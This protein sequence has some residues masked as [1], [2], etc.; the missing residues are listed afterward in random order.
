M[1]PSATFT[2][3]PLGPSHDRA[4]FS[5]GEQALD[6]YIRQQAS[7]DAKRGVT[8]VFVAVETP[9][10]AGSPATTIAGYYTLSATSCAKADL[11]PALAKRLP[12]YLVPAA[13]LGRLAVDQKHQGQKLGTFLLFDAFDRVVEASRLMAIH[14]LI[15]DAKNAQVAAWY[16]KYGFQPFPTAPLR[17]FIPVAT[18]AKAKSAP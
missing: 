17:L 9:A 2:I 15:V 4:A 11:P 16:Q 12:H 7:Q 5:C 1:A 10:T 18:L 3:E 14:A 8:R 13:I 6:D